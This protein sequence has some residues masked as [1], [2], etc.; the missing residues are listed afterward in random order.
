M[1]RVEQKYLDELANDVDK[2]PD[3]F[4]VS[5]WIIERIPSIFNGDYEEFIKTKLFIAN[6]LGIDSCSVIFVG[7]SCTGFSLN[8]DKDFKIFDELSDIDIAI[9]SHHY[10]NIAW[11][12]MK[13][14]DIGLQKG[15]VRY[16]I[17]QHRSHYIFDGTIATDSFLTYLPFGNEWN[18]VIK[19]LEKNPIFCGREVHFRLYQDHKSLIDYHRN[20]VKRNLP[21]LLGV[22]AQSI[23]LKNE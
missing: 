9:I 16:S 13:S 18:S 21:I 8:P 17:A 15:K 14:V 12:W 20:N 7:S 5:K 22:E 1:A 10:F 19:E 3:D 6:R 2:G 4:V 11:H 23:E